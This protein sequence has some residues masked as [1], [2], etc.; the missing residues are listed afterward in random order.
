MMQSQSNMIMS[1]IMIP[2]LGIPL[3][4]VKLDIVSG[5]DMCQG[6]LQKTYNHVVGVFKEHMSDITNTIYM[7]CK[8]CVTYHQKIDNIYMLFGKSV[9]HIINIGTTYVCCLKN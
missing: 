9:L 6:I 4:T 2:N 8:N 1:G 7:L 5:D 3:Y